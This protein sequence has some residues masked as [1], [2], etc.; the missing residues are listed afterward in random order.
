MVDIAEE[1]GIITSK[2]RNHSQAKF[3]S[4]DKNII[5]PLVDEWNFIEVEKI[6]RNR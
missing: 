1:Q 3:V 2:D 4:L 5:Q 6:G